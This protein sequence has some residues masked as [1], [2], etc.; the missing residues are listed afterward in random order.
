MH[1]LFSAISYFPKLAVLQKPAVL[2][3]YEGN[4]LRLLIYDVKV[5]YV[6]ELLC[7]FSDDGN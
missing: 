6:K 4:S 2:V 1:S 3:E 5:L 7:A